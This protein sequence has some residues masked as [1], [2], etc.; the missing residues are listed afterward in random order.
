M[1]AVLEARGVGRVLA[2]EREVVLVR[3]ATLRAPSGAFTAIVGPSGCGKSSLLYL[4]GLLDRPTSGEIFVEGRAVSDLSGDAL[5]RLRLERFG[6]V[7]QFHFLL[8]EFTALENV[9]LPMER[10]GRISREQARTRAMDLLEELG[11][12][13]KATRLPSHLS[14][15]ER[16]RVAI[17]RSLANDPLVVLC[18]EPTGNLDSR[19]SARVVETLHHLAH[20]EQRAV[21]CVTHDM[22]IAGGADLQVEMLDG[23][24]E[25]IIDRRENDTAACTG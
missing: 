16:Q 14:G 4:L 23:R 15:G 21:I 24:I 12:A 13:D 20:D 2:G 17:A 6:F 1:S 18:D 10:L 25:R 7:F 9:R 8:P 11:I 3:D 22:D 5:A 19:N